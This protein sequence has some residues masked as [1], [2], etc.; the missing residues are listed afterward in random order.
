MKN[1]DHK[2]VVELARDYGVRYAA[3]V[4]DVTPRTVRGWRQ[5]L[6]KENDTFEVED[7]PTGELPI[8]ELIA[9]RIN[10]YELKTDYMDK[11]DLI[12]VKIKM[13]GPIGI[14]HFGDPHVDDD[15]TDLERLLNHSKLVNKTEGMFAG[16]VGDVQNNWIGRIAHLYSQQSTSAKDSWRLAEYFISSVPWLYLVGGNHDA[17]SGTGDPLEWIMS[18]QGGVYQNFSVRL[19]LQFPNKKNVRINSKHDFKGNSMWNTAYGVGRAIQLGARDHILTCGHTHVSGYQVV[20]DPSNGLISHGLRIASYKIHDRYA[21]EK[22]FPDQNIFMCPVTII[23][24]QYDDNDPRL[25]TTIFDPYEA[26]DYLTW[27]RSKHGKN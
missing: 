6:R 10:R 5:K 8:K 24:P 13:N 21:I 2:E 9:D 19:N 1:V 12:N 14:A 11:T 23:D 18:H 26:A 20:K 4:Y 3:E 15:G 17:W 7:L 22:G 25:I 16:N 27:K